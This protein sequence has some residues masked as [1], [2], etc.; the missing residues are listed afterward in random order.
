MRRDHLK[1]RLAQGRDLAR[2]VGHEPHRGEAELLQ[3][4]RRKIEAA[5][6]LAEAQH[7]VGVVGVEA[8]LLQA[9]GPDFVGDAVAAPLL[10]EVE[11][12]AAALLAHG[13][14]GAAQLVAAIAFEAAEE[15]AGEAGGMDARENGAVGRSGL[16]TMTAI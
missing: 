14:Y 12:D 1:A 10:I 4:L 3:H 11:H 6:I 8:L 5:L 2:V 7:L 13:L 16:P 15:I 9:I